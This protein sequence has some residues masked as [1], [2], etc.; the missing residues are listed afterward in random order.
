MKMVKMF[1]VAFFVLIAV[2]ITQVQAQVTGTVDP[3]NGHKIA[4]RSYAYD[5]L[6]ASAFGDTI[7]T[8]QPA[9]A[10][11]YVRYIIRDTANSKTDSLYLEYKNYKGEWIQIGAKNLLSGSVETVLVPG[12]GKTVVYESI[13][14]YGY[15]YRIRRVNVSYAGLVKTWVGIEASTP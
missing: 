14:Y 9:G 10:A 4:F 1:V 12:D 8:Y 15:A 7:T 11:E 3:G 6:N 5:T 13:L 2:F